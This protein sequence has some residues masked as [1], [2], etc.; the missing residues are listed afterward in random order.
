MSDQD[1]LTLEGRV[2]RL[3][4]S[5]TQLEQENQLLKNER[6]AWAQERAKLI[7]QNEMARHKVEAMIEHLRSLEVGHEQG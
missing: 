2:D 3:L 7:K 4:E 6:V 1:I 5:Y